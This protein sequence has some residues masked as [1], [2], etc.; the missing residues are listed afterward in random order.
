MSGSAMELHA[1]LLSLE[2]LLERTKE[3]RKEFEAWKASDYR[4]PKEIS[5]LPH[6]IS[7]G[8]VRSLDLL[9]RDAI[10]RDVPGRRDLADQWYVN[11]P[12]G[13]SGPSDLIHELVVKRGLLRQAIAAARASPTDV[14]SEAKEPAPSGYSKLAE[15]I[16]HFLEDSSRG[17]DQYEKNVFVMTRFEDGNKTLESIDQVIRSTVRKHGLVAH[18]ADDRCYPLDRNLWDNVCTYMICCKYGIAVLENIMQDEF[19][20]NVALEYGFMRALGKPTLLLREK[21]FKPRADILG[22][23]WADF[24][25]LE[26]ETSV[27]SAI[28]RWVGD[29]SL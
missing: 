29:L 7:F 18:R 23:L 13:A 26:I 25:I 17:C 1:C 3:F 9:C 11:E 21:R 6:V 12:K 19:N 10:L 28:E 2:D 15:P 20:P 16:R 8:E 22:T 14:G 5:D 4:H 24:D 27:A